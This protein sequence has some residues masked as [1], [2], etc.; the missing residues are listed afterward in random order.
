[1]INLFNINNYIIDTASY[2]N[3]LHDSCVT[4]LEN[5]IASY[6]GA[7][8]AVALNSAT[9]AIF[10]SLLNKN[11]NIIIPS[12]IPPVVPNAIHTG[13]NTYSFNDNISWVGDSYV[14]H[15]F[16]DY[17]I[18]D[19][20]QK[21]E[22]N[23][24]NNEFSDNDLM[25]FSF[26][27]TKPIGSFDGGMIVSNDLDKITYIREMSLNGMTFASNNWERKNKYIGYKM[28][29]NSIQADI[30]LKNFNKYEN[31]RI[32]LD[33]IRSYYN[34]HL[35]QTNTSYHLY[36][37]NVNDN[38]KFIDY[39]K[40][41]GIVCGIHYKALHLDSVYCNEQITLKLSEEVS[42]TTA[43]IPFH[44]NLSIHDVKKIIEHIKEYKN[45]M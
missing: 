36:R 25:I 9:S 7:K 45:G 24:F 4:E 41:K 34:E 28:Y 14:L 13:G 11:I 16:G 30:A 43:S 3:A 1:M 37:I 31:K 5:T 26:Y 42:Q 15:D 29:M 35:E 27:P 21:I 18:V 17:K 39:M 6:V 33:N 38:N 19:S 32:I 12:I 10:L 44:E 40:Q 2:R 23:Q 20:A 22:P 8:Y